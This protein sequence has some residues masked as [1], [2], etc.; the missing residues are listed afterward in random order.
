MTLTN[1]KNK[2]AFFETEK[3]R[4][5]F[6]KGAKLLAISLPFLFAAPIIITIGFKVLKRNESLWLLVLG[7]T[8]AIGTIVMV[9][10]AFRL[11]LKALFSK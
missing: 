6:Y 10:Q 11:I 4:K 8:L 9:T 1:K 2:Q 3:A 5:T 7:C